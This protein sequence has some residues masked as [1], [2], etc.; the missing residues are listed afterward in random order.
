MLHGFI[1]QVNIFRNRFLGKIKIFKN[2]LFGLC[3]NASL[4]LS[5]ALVVSST[6]KRNISNFLSLVF[7]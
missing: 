3:K 6:K 1:E 4:M 5:L 7:T 2:L